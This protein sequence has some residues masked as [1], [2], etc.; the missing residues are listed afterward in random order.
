M[1]S[2]VSDN[3]LHGSIPKSICHLVDIELL[4]L[5]DNNL[6]GELD[7]EY[8]FLKLK[9]LTYLALSFNKLSVISKP[10]INVI[11]PKFKTLFLASCNLY[12]FPYFLQNQDE[13]IF[14]DLSKKKLHGQIPK[15]FWNVSKNTLLYLNLDA[16]FLTGFNQLPVVLQWS[17]LY[18]L[19]IANNILQGSL[20]IPPPS[21]I[22][23]NVSNNRLTGEVSPFFCNLTYISSLD[24]SNNSLGGILPQCLGNIINSLSVLYLQNN[25]FHG[26]IPQASVKG[27]KLRTINLSQNQLQ[28]KI[29][30]SLAGCDQFLNLGNNQIHD[31]F[32]SWLGTLVV[33]K[34]LIL[35]SNEFCGEIEEPKSAFDFPMLRIIDLSNNS[36]TGKLP[37]QHFQIWNAMKT[38]DAD[39]L[40]YWGADTS[41]TNLYNKPAYWS[42]V[43]TNKGT[44]IFYER[45]QELFVAIDLSTN[46]FEGEIPMDIGNLKGLRLLNLS[47]N[48]LTGH[49]SSS[50]ENLT[51]LKTLDLS[52][53]KLSGEIPQQLS[54]LTFLEFLNVSHNRLTGSIPHGKQFDTYQ[55]NS[56]KD[57]PGLCGDPLSKKCGILPP[58]PPSAAGGED[59]SS[60]SLFEFGW[61]VVLMG[62]ACGLVVGVLVGHI[63]IERK[64]EWFMTT[65]GIKQQKMVRVKTRGPTN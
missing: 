33:L 61:K 10:N 20:P 38:S 12:E 28:G 54:Q 26:N 46:K 62:Y 34:V 36:F 31:I 3:L 1:L 37:S 32:P 14:L 58:P 42:M 18:D 55:N 7:F 57:N 59:R 65:F 29:P 5:D 30:G 60:S 17:T 64:P 2:D 44:K 52:Q 40:R 9:N 16:N 15:S 48:I 22:S 23:Y 63:V 19:S 39:S 4:Y 13:L 41:D 47:N 24:L 50:F 8:M 45:I 43:I 27:C 25:N 53:N 51:Q 56:F 6:T 21:I 11:L 49:I 35:G